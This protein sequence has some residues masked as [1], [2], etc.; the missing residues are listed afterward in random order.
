MKIRRLLLL[1]C[2]VL[3]GS[4]AVAGQRPSNTAPEHV[5][6]EAQNPP[7]MYAHGPA[8]AGLYPAVI[9]EAFRR[10][11]RPVQLEALPWKR[12][13]AGLEQGVWGVGGIYMNAE[14]LQKFDYSAPFFDERLMLYTTRER[15]FEFLTVADLA[16]KAVGVMR[17]WSYGDAFDAAV[18]V[19][20]LKKD[21]SETDAANF[22]K[23][24]AGRVDVVIAAPETWANLRADFA[25]EGEVVELPT[26]LARN[27]V[28]LVFLKSANKTA[29]LEAFDAAV[30][31]MQ[32]DG[33]MGRLVREYLR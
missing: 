5:A 31:G 32:A 18:A 2:L 26:P 30:A 13:L 14:R 20:A 23:L 24:R 6:V 19:N 17:G 16:G 33:T 15:R 3:L 22:A 8:A 28:H 1:L 10:M 12:A 9:A 4:G 21:E 25:P 27:P 11:G 7:F 29:L